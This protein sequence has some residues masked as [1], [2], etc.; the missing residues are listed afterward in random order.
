MGS[1]ALPKW[2]IRSII[3]LEL[4]RVDRESCPQCRLGTNKF[5][6]KFQ[7][8]TYAFREDCVTLVKSP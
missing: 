7:E 4:V 2:A 6:T 5:A 8:S 3:I 1:E